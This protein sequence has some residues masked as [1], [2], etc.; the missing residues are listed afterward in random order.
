MGRELSPHFPR[1]LLSPH[2]PRVLLAALY[3]VRLVR[4][5]ERLLRRQ[6][7]GHSNAIEQYFHVMLFIMLY[8]LFLFMFKFVN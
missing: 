2:F 5:R 3:F 7:C 4:E 1:F 6:V 8:K